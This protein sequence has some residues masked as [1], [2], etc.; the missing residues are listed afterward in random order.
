MELLPF[1]KGLPD[2]LKEAAIEFI[3]LTAEGSKICYVCK[4]PVEQRKQVGECIYVYPCGHRIGH[5]P[6]GLLKEYE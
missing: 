5:N 1:P 2:A 6:P 4:H 3:E